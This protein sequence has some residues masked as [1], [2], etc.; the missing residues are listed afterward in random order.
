MYQTV[1]LKDAPEVK[2]IVLAAFAGYRKLKATL[3]EFHGQNINSYW[4]GGSK[5][6]YA[7]V[8]LET[9]KRLSLPTH[10]HPYFE[11][12]RQGFANTENAAISVDHA[13]NITLNVLPPNCVLVEAGTFCGKPATAHIYVLAENMTKLLGN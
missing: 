13:G 8:D 12:V 10:S 9:G 3:S 5:S 6:E 11:V 4:D 7:V 1:T 2:R